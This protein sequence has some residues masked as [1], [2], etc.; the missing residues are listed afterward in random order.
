MTR[1]CA[2]LCRLPD[3]AS[4]EQTKD[5]SESMLTKLNLSIVNV[6]LVTAP[7]VVVIDTGAPGSVPKIVAALARQGFRPTDIS[8]ILLT[9]AH[10]DH[11]GSAAELRT[12]SKAPVAVHEEDVPMLRRGDNG[13]MVA[14]D[15]EAAM[16]QPFVDRPFPGLEPDIVLNNESRLDDLGME[17]QLLHTPGH[18]EGSIS[19]LFENGDGIVGDVLRGGWLGGTL[20]ATQPKYPFFLYDL[21]DKGRIHGSVQRLL[22][23]GVKRFYT[24]HGGPLA[25]ERVMQWLSARQVE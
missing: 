23:A 16:S 18:T 22:G 24:G 7:R 4:V 14:T 15:W 10:S 21:N 11:A 20:F 6:Y 19:L 1:I 25:Q 9:H 2:R 13:K 5:L 3:A 8:L 12:I 17:A